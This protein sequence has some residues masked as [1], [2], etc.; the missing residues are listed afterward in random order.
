MALAFPLP[1]EDFADH[2]HLTGADFWLDEAVATAETGGGA[3]VRVAYGSEMW[4][5]SA[6]IGANSREDAALLTARLNY[7]R[8]A[9]GSFLLYPPNC[10][11]QDDPGGRKVRGYRPR[12][13]FVAEDGAH[14]RIVGLPRRYL[15]LPGDFIG[16]EYGSPARRALHQVV[17]RR[18]S[19]SDGVMYEV[20][21]T[22]Y[23]RP[24][25]A[26]A[27]TPVILRKP[28]IKAV[29]EPGSYGG[30]PY[31]AGHQGGGSFR[32]RQVLL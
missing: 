7:V 1:L 23:V 28:A 17:D 20:Q 25:V 5:G 24:G 10:H 4:V 19:H 11:P 3:A 29:I 21:L 12:I 18:H 27:S 6:S 2:L 26:L 16:F 8:R 32:W 22:P 13:D 30:L 31:L 14:V 9:N 15:L